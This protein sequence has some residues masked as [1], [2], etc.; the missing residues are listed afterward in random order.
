MAMAEH[1]LEL[2]PRATA[3]Q[4]EKTKRLLEEYQSCARIC[5][6]FEEEGIETLC[7]TERASYNKSTSKVKRIRRAVKLIFDREIREIIEYR[8]LQ[9]NTYTD[10]IQQFTKA[11]DDRT[12]DRKLN[13]GIEAVAE[14]LILF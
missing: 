5:A 2:F 7:E 12:V 4:I 13:K 11:M 8:Y 9:E 6:A 3:E 1:Q 10:T 14:S